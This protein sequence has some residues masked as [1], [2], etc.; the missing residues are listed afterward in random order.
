MS[1]NIKKKIV[2]DK[3]SLPLYPIKTLYVIKNYTIKQIQSMFCTAN[4]QELQLDDDDRTDMMVW[5]FVKHKKTKNLVILCLITKSSIQLAKDKAD[6]SACCAHE[7]LHVTAD[8]LEDAGIQLNQSTQEAYAY[9][10]EYVT[11][12]IYK[13]LYK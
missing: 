3:Y 9:Y 2:I 8:V 10:T 13:T 5:T 7:A 1:S 4:D 11:R 12:C 6:G